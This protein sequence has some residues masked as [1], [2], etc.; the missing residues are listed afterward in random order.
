MTEGEVEENT[1][2]P[3]YIIRRAEIVCAEAKNSNPDKRPSTGDEFRANHL[4]ADKMAAKETAR[5]ISEP[6]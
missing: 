5:N 1:I 4:S 6:K 2:I 3:E